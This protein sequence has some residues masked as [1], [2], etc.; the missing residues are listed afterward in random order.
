M[1]DSSTATAV[2]AFSVKSGRIMLSSA[3]NPGPVNLPDGSYT[4]GDAFM[5]ILGGR[6]IRVQASVSVDRN[7][8]VM[9]RPAASALMQVSDIPLPSGTFISEDKAS[10][11]SVMS[12]RPTAFTPPGSSPKE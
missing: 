4:N 9:L 2:T 11:I 8:I 12:G 5:V 3:A 1:P 10:S 7:R 6:I